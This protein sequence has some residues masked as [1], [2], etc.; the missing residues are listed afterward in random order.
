MKD[1]T[2]EIQI[3]E[4]ILNITNKKLKRLKNKLISKLILLIRSKKQFK[5]CQKELKKKINK[6]ELRELNAD[7]LVF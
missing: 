3:L 1:K 7:L 5:I 6:T 2:A 4:K